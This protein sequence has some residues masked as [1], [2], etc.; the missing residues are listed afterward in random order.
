M[1]SSTIFSGVKATWFGHSSFMLEADGITV[2]TDP[3][4]LPRG[5]RMADIILY[6]H[7][8]FDHC[9]AVPSITSTR[10]AI[11]GHGCKLPGRVIEIGA[12]E[13]AG[14]LAIEAVHAYNIGK[15]F[16]PKGAGAGFLLSFR[17]AT[18]YFAGDTDLIPEMKNYKCDIA[19]LPIG[20][21]YTMDAQEAADA[22]ALIMPKV[23]IPMH[24]NYLSDL[25]AD[26]EAFRFAVEQKTGGKVDVRILTPSQ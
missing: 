16:H 25:K 26:P 11:I 2:Y 1:A 10:T 15:Q 24:Y 5:A 22:A 20:G 6:S 19:L 3:F 8:H 14:S 12:K 18:V 9:V 17:Q 23:A 13:K 21:I 7:G 4:V